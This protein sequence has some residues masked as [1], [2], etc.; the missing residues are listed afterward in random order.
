M[1]WVTSLTG[2][3]NEL[4]IETVFSV[5]VLISIILMVNY[6]ISLTA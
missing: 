1:F 5:F 6:T 4:I 3:M 2:R